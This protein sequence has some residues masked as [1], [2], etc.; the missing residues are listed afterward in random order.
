MISII[1]PVYNAALYLDKCLSSLKRQTYSD[2]EIIMI[3][4][5]STDG[6]AGI[7]KYYEE[8]DARFRYIY[9]ENAGVSAARNKGLQLAKGE[10]IGF[11]DSDDWVED[12]MYET[13]HT[14]LEET[15]SDVSIISFDCGTSDGAV[16]QE[17]KDSHILIFDAEAAIL[18]MHQGKN[19]QGHL[20]NKLIKRNLLNN[21]FLDEKVVICED[22]LFMWMVFFRC[23]KVA[24][25]NAKKYHYVVVPE[26]AMNG[27]MKDSYWSVQSAARKMMEYM[28]E[29]YPQHKQY[30][31]RT[32]VLCNMM[33]AEKAFRC[34]CLTRDVYRKIKKEIKD[35]YSADVKK[36]FSFKQRA[37]TNIFSMNRLAYL[38][39][40]NCIK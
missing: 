28:N 12:D 20:C 23:K 32:V 24:F 26:S 3:D 13:L 35:N 31:Q 21:L 25:L 39:L 37:K 4:D 16:I 11:C 30:A 9:Q 2:I 7:C 10:Y 22:M 38:L 15:Q 8:A 33:I 6:S 5:G 36:L 1:V 40:M 27:K 17:S 29:Y 14:I 19:F 34:K 18:E